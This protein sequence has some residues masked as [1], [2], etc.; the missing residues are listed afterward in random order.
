MRGKVWGGQQ[1]VSLASVQLYA[2]GTTGDGS[3]AAPIAGASTTTASDGT[4]TFGSYTCPTPTTL[5]YLLSSGGNPGLPG[6]VNNSSIVLVAALGQCQQLSSSTYILVNEVTT[7]AAMAALWPY[8]SSPTGIGSGTSDAGNLANAFVLA[9]E[10]ASTS[11]GSAPGVPASGYSVPVVLIDT[12]ADILAACVNTSGGVANDGSPCGYL[13]AYSTPSGG[14]APAGITTSLADIFNNPTINLSNLLG[15]ASASSPFQPILSAPPSSWTVVLQTTPTI[16]ALPGASAITYGQTLAA[17][18]LTGGTGSVSGTFAWTTAGATPG[19]GTDTESVTFTP[20]DTTDYATAT[21]SV[22]LTV[23]RATPVI[24]ELPA[25]ST[26]TYGQKLSASTLTGGTASVSGTFAFTTPGLAPSAGTDTERITFTPTDTT[27]YVTATGSVTVTVNQVTPTVT[28]WPRASAITV[29]Q[30]LSQSTL[31]GG[32]ASV[33]GTFAFATPGATPGAG[34][35]PE[36][37]IFTPSD[38]TDYTTVTGSV[39]VTVNQPAPVPATVD[40]GTTYQKIRG[41]GGASVWLGQMNSAEATALF[42]PT[43]GLNL[44]I[45]R[46]RIDP[47]GSASG[48]GTYN[49][50]YETYQWDQEAANGAEAVANNPNA[51]VFASPWSPP[52]AW[53]LNGS[54]S[55]SDQGETWNQSYN[56]S[57]S[58]GTGYC[59]GYLNPLDY[60]NYASYLEDFVKFFDTANGFSLYAVSMQNEPEENVTYESCVWT[61]DQM[62]A[63]VAGYAATVTSDQFS[64]KLIMPESD[65]FN[66]VDAAATLNDTNAQGRVSIVGGHIYGGPPSAPYSIPAGDSPKE[67]WMTEYGPLSTAQLTFAQALNPY[68]VSIHDTLV[69]GQYN[70]YVWWGAFSASTGSCA[71]AAGT[72]GLI[73]DNGNV[74]AMG[75]IMGQY[76]KFI[77][78]GYVRASATANPISGV[79][80]SAYTGEDQSNTQHYVIVAINTSTSSSQTLSF[81]LNNGTVTSLTPYQSDTAAGL[82]PQPAVTVTAGQFT[83]SLPATSITTFVQ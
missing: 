70:A 29:G 26:I 34:T 18:T 79:Y 32:T 76:S 24:T 38:S 21:G 78:R 67:I 17:S 53:K 13:F 11:T 68:G 63:W 9:G 50:P 15:L 71:T 40:F 49:M 20:T 19:A 73:D 42:S 60:G 48:G 75:E 8:Y 83:Y 43:S 36:S 57:C 2:V 54:S 62:D 51:I 44:S 6:N 22:T 12:L 25:A 1:P 59:G 7:V 55:V 14:S 47:E 45:L 37:V 35:D 82:V 69:N 66:P 56:S 77:Q 3:A 4:F 33:S 61:P 41:F 81:T 65:V 74:M 31:T 52:P 58:E 28:A 23:N 46:V 5:V 80:V 10:F 64:T 27:D 30:I 16:T 39:N 72:C